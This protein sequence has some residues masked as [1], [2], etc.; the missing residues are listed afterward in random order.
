MMLTDINEGGYKKV[1]VLYKG[2]HIFNFLLFFVFQL[3]DDT[4]IA[5]LSA[6]S[7]T[8]PYFPIEGT[9]FGP[10]NR[11]MICLNCRRANKPDAPL[12]KVWFLVD[13]GCNCTF[14]DEKTIDA[15]LGQNRSGA[16]F[17]KVAI[18]VSFYYFSIFIVNILF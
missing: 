1:S 3:F 13:T 6:G 7:F 12:V 2:G 16:T 11:L 5:N 10:N 4:G 18:Q 14:I 17:M 15:L 8:F 9:I